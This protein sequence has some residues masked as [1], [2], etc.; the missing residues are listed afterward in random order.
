MNR[1]HAFVGLGILSDDRAAISQPASDGFTARLA[2]TIVSPADDKMRDDKF[3][4]RT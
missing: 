3:A 1:I 4:E 2:A